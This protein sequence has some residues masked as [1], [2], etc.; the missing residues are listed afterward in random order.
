MS[1]LSDHGRL[2]T[3]VQKVNRDIPIYFGWPPATADLTGKPYCITTLDGIIDDTLATSA[4][5][6]SVD[7][8]WPEG[9]QTKFLTDGERMVNEFRDKFNV[10]DVVVLTKIDKNDILEGYS[11]TIQVKI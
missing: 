4:R 1:W 7:V 6:W 9:L 5:L 3:A 8:T 11:I 2:M 10:L